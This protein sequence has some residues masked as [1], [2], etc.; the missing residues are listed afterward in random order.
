MS[1]FDQFL[2]EEG[3]AAEKHIKWRSHSL[4]A[5]TVY[6]ARDVISN[7]EYRSVIEF[8]R[9]SASADS[10]GE[11]VMRRDIA[12]LTLLRRCGLR[13]GEAVHLTPG[14][15]TGFHRWCLE[16]KISKTRAGIRKL[17]LY[18]LLDKKELIELSQFVEMQKKNHKSNNSFLF[19]NDKSSEPLTAAQLGRHIEALLSGAGIANE[20]A[21]GLRHAF[22]SSLFAAFWLNL[23]KPRRTEEK[24]IIYWTLK[25]YARPAV[26]GR[27]AT[28]LIYLQQLLGHADLRV[29]FER[30]VH[31]IEF[32]LADSVR[33]YEMNEANNRET[34]HK[35]KVAWLI[36]MDVEDLNRRLKLEPKDPVR[37]IDAA[38][39]AT[40]DWKD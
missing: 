22:A 36:G 31:I 26:E 2:I 8:V 25:K 29:T 20:S 38:R 40:G 19:R 24:G 18:L 39:M 28:D 4:R 11:L 7:W 14:K 9:R 12:A 37:I 5:P 10:T 21:H 3:R 34:L 17:P 27:A 35:N 1:Q 30:Y 33:L 16:I 32:A 6:Q 13:V 15:F 23:T